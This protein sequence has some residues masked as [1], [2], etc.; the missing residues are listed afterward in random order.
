MK[1]LHQKVNWDIEDERSEFLGEIERII[2]NWTR[3]LPDLRDIFRPQEI[4]LLLIDSAVNVI[5]DG[6]ENKGRLFIEFVIKTGY[7]DEPEVDK[8][9]KQPLV[10]RTTAVHH[11]STYCNTR[12]HPELIEKIFSIYDRFDVIYDETG[13]THLHVAC[14]YGYDDI[15][16]KFL[17]AGQDPNYLWSST[18]DSPMNLALESKHLN[19]AC[20]LLKHGAD[21]NLA[22]NGFTPMHWIMLL[23]TSFEVSSMLESFF[24]ICDDLKKSVQVDAQD[25]WGQTPLFLAL[26]RHHGSDVIELLL[27]RG[28]NPHSTNKNGLWPIDMLCTKRSDDELVQMFQIMDEKYQL[29]QIDAQDKCVNTPLHVAVTKGLTKLVEFLLRKGANPNSPNAEG[30]TALHLTC[31]RL[32]QA[33]EGGAAELLKIC[34]DIQRTVHI[35]AQNHAGDTPLH[36]AL[37]NGLMDTVELLMK[38]GANP[39]LANEDGSTPLHN[40]CNG[41][42]DD[43]DLAKML[44]E[45]PERKGH[46]LHTYMVNAED[47]SGNTP[48]DLAVQRGHKK[49]EELLLSIEHVR[50]SEFEHEVAMAHWRVIA[51]QIR[52][53]DWTE[54]LPNLRDIF[55]REEIDWLLTESLKSVRVDAYRTELIPLVQFVAQTSYK[56]EPEVD[57]NDKPSS[58]RTTP[59]HHTFEDSLILVN[60]HKLVDHLFQ[61]YDRFDVNYT[62]E[63]GVTHFHVACFFGCDEVVEKFLELGQDPNILVPLT[64][65]TPLH[66][67][68]QYRHKKATEL[69]L[70][71]GANPNL[72]N[73]W[74]VTPLHNVCN[75]GHDNADLAEILF[76][77]SDEKH[78]PIQVNAQ[79]KLGWTPLHFSL[80]YGCKKGIVQVLLRRGA[81]PNLPNV[82]GSTPLHTICNNIHNSIYH[83]NI[84]LAKLFFEINDERQQMVEVNARDNSGNAPLHLALKRRL[85]N[86][87]EL[88][89][90][91]GADANLANEK[92]S[93]PL[94]MICEGKYYYPFDMMGLFFKINDERKQTVEVNARD[95]CGRTPLQLAVPNLNS[96]AVDLLLNH[97]ADLSLF[98]FPSESYLDQL[99]R[100]KL[101]CEDQLKLMLACLAIIENFEKKGYELDRS[102]ALTIMK[103]FAK[104]ELFDRWE[105]NEILQQQHNTVV[106]IAHNYTRLQ[107]GLR[108]AIYIQYAPQSSRAAAA[109]I[110]RCQS[111]RGSLTD[112][113]QSHLF[114][115]CWRFWDCCY[116]WSESSSSSSPPQ[117]LLTTYEFL[118]LLLVGACCVLG[119]MSL[120]GDV[121]PF[122]ETP[123]ETD[124]THSDLTIKY[125]LRGLLEDV[126]D[127]PD[128]DL[129]K[130]SP[131]ASPLLPEEVRWLYRDDI[132]KIWIEFCGYDSLRIENSWREIQSRSS[133]NG[134]NSDN[135]VN[136]VKIVV[137]GGMYEVD[138]EQKK[139][140]SI[141]WPDTD[142]KEDNSPGDTP[143]KGWSL[144]NIVRAGWTAKEGSSPTPDNPPIQPDQAKHG[145]AHDFRQ[146]YSR[147]HLN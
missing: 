92:G 29:G 137:R 108:T 44:L 68:L 5:L 28:A 140:V 104:Y 33:D 64:G 111:C 85:E 34:D 106:Y 30:S 97:G 78:H 47:R 99:L 71:Y 50:T 45:L 82:E 98:V 19:A 102:V 41:D 132:N 134:N 66:L 22:C 113:T 123:L 109:T 54:Q 145:D 121:D 24:E 100:Q 74:D 115:D 62:D 11:L 120:L 114:L 1:S 69:L 75:S 35:D 133:E 32:C 7:K 4:D 80:A 88:L 127:K 76:E 12:Y 93:T 20:L 87:T 63:S 60:Y 49:L 67:A 146:C 83:S 118:L 122:S 131:Y 56:D 27:R 91:R 14:F 55:R 112:N 96:H 119:R 21:P 59:L 25:D 142:D 73:V 43:V 125:N 130:Q 141:Y 135:F 15:I 65:D 9:A 72:A 36:L 95:C 86:L 38:R 37:N 57:I 10:H 53:K 3:Q 117:V 8:E 81:N 77:M 6:L 124:L 42:R 94:H 90:R 101:H 84:D 79:N 26:A 128:T 23:R 61:V 139:C 13:N 52:V 51:A 129:P 58:S 89:L 17:E 143:S 138:L 103:L 46:P 70:K 110:Y 147:K 107:R 40:I 18:G 126:D 39:T 16:E 144:W 2:K 31:S 105:Y 116:G 48:L 136:N